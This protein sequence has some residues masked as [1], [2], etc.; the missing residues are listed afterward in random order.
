MPPPHAEKGGE[1]E[2]E[3]ESGKVDSIPPPSSFFSDTEAGLLGLG[4]REVLSENENMN[5]TTQKVTEKVL[6]KRFF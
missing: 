2:R 6:S 3:R 5:E 1:G 4:H